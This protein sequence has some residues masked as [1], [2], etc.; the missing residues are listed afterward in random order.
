MKS[1][2]T[3]PIYSAVCVPTKS[4]KNGTVRNLK[5]A[6]GKSDWDYANR[7]GFTCRFRIQKSWD[8]SI[9]VDHQKMNFSTKRDWYLL[10]RMNDFMYSLHG[11]PVCSVLSSSCGD[12]QIR[13]VKAAQE[14]MDFISHHEIYQFIGMQFDF[15]NEMARILRVGYVVLSLGQHGR[16]TR[17]I[18][19][20]PTPW[21]YILS[22]G[23]KGTISA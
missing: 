15:T 16:I 22:T 6:G 3:V 23:R 18:N 12:W 5:D 4:E 21:S 19:V 7:M 14:K 2:C 8:T 1:P 20:L 11:T 9:R 10:P 13:V 17:E